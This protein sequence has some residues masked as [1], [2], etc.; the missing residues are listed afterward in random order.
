MDEV[1][2]E[3]QHLIDSEGSD[4]DLVDNK[5]LTGEHKDLADF[6]DDKDTD[7]EK[8]FNITSIDI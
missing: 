7:S 6:T 1:L 4:Q 3:E 5:D 8:V 2:K